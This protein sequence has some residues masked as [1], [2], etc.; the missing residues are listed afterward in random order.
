MMTGLKKAYWGSAKGVAQDQERRRTQEMAGRGASPEVRQAAA[1]RRRQVS[2]LR[3]RGLTFEAIGKQLGISRNLAYKHYRRG[4]R[5]IPAA[6][7][8]EMRNLEGERIT[9]A[10][11]RIYTELAGRPNPKFPNDPTKT[12]RPSPRLVLRLIDTVLKISH[13]EALLYGLYAP[14]N[15]QAKSPPVQPVSDDELDRQLARLTDAEQDEFMRLHRKM[16]GRGVDLGPEDDY[17]VEARAAAAKAWCAANPERGTELELRIIELKPGH[18]R[19]E[20]PEVFSYLAR[21]DQGQLR[22]LIQKARTRMD[23]GMRPVESDKRPE[24]QTPSAT[25]NGQDHTPSPVATAPASPSAKLEFQ[26]CP[27]CGRFPRLDEE[28]IYIN[29]IPVWHRDC[30]RIG[31]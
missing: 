11:R 1:E 23:A 28:P 8:D 21:N 5:L 26:P 15:V 16:D 18:E 24:V 27:K 7:V 30:R 10:R 9:D 4:L 20:Q 19:W 14:R 6:A 13:H 17:E 29:M 2:Q 31:G 3:L 22:D 12:I 25:S